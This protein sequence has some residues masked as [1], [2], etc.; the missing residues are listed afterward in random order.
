MAGGFGLLAGGFADEGQTGENLLFHLLQMAFQHQR[1]TQAVAGFEHH[2]VVGEAKALFIGFNA[3]VRLHHSRTGYVVHRT[4]FQQVT[5]AAD[6]A[7]VPLFEHLRY[8]DVG[9][10]IAHNVSPF[11]PA[12]S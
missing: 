9:N 2:A 3:D 4:A 10:I 8:G 12:R 5:D 1:H 6:R 7:A 11:M